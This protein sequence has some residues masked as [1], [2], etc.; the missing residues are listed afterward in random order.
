[1]VLPSVPFIHLLRTALFDI[2]IAKYGMNYQ[3]K[4]EAKIKST[5]EVF[6][7]M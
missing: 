7:N 6:L 2:K 1:M 3:L 4:L 5:I